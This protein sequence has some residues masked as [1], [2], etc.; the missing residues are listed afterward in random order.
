MLDLSKMVGWKD[1]RKARDEKD[2]KWLESVGYIVDGV[3]VRYLD[4]PAPVDVTDAYGNTHYRRNGP[5]RIQLS[6]KTMLEYAR[7][8]RTQEYHRNKND[9][10]KTYI[11]WR[12]LGKDPSEATVIVK[13][14]V[15]AKPKTVQD[16]EFDW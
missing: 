1:P 6:Q 2:L 12:F 16:D 10:S 11:E 5:E 15:P 14:S 8:L 13:V 3:D 4:N 9:G 7:A